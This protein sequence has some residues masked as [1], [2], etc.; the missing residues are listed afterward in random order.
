MVRKWRDIVGYEGLYKVSN[1]GQILNVKRNRLLKQCNRG[2]GY[3]C[4][5]LYSGK[6][7]H[8]MFAVHQL[9]AQHFICFVPNNNVKYDINHI[10]ENKL[11]NNINNL[12]IVS[13]KGNINHGTRT[14][15]MIKTQR[16]GDRC[17]PIM[18]VET[19]KTYI[20]ASEAERDTGIHQGNISQ[21]CRGKRKTAGGYH[22]KLAGDLPTTDVTV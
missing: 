2:N 17:I 3:L 12:N 19:N 4:V 8:K 14:E 7:N 1:D 5:A 22:W 11:D 13:R 16:S 10:N 9:V 21:C 18:C 15:R 6:G 20:S